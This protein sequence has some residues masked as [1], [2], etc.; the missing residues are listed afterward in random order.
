VKYA[1]EV[2]KAFGTSALQKHGIPL[3]KTFT[4]AETMII[5][6]LS[7]SLRV[8]SR[9]ATATPKPVHSKSLQI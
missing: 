4:S 1:R 6:A 2:A 7:L 5:S 3:L 8:R 9:H